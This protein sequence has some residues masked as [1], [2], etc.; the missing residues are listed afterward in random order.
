[1]TDRRFL[2][3]I[4]LTT[5]L[6]G[7]EEKQTAPRREPPPPAAKPAACDGERKVNDPTNVKFFPATA[8]P[9]C[10]DPAGS[11]KAYGDGTKNPINGICNLFDGECEIYLSG[12]VERVVE[13]RYVDGKGSG[14]TIDVY[15]SKYESSEAAYAMFT[16]R[17]VGDLDPA[18]PD[19]AK[20]TAGGGAAA[21]GIGNAYLWRGSHLAEITYNDAAANS[22]QEIRKAADS[23]LPKLVK[24]FGD[25]L[26]GEPDLPPSAAKLPKE[27]QLVLGVRF[28]NDKLL[29]IEGTGAGAFGYYAD[30]A[31]RW[32]ILS[33]A[34][35][36]AAQAKDL[37]RTFS[38]TGGAAKEK[39]IGDEATRFMHTPMGLPKTEWLI[40]RKGGWV[41][42]IGDEDRVLREGMTPEEHR[43]K[44]LTLDAKR[45]LLKQVLASK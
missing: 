28:L 34:K 39:G 44:T 12:G 3:A 13:A 31:V 17:V 37:M 20:P 8:G 36:D 33:V 27:K 16:K 32:R 45:E 1:M 10:L 21:L 41:V 38:Q 24:A 18:H 2:S 4:A 7:C 35:G 14:A 19:I 22:E 15:L 29:G 40:A 43:D 30:G 26:P 6:L 23:L 5:C 11:D 42:G 25:K 9:F